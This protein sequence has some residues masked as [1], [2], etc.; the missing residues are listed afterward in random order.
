LIDLKIVKEQY[1]RMPDEELLRFATNESQKLTIES[2]HLLKS[3][4]ESR[5]L[6]LTILERVQTEKELAEA[7]QL[8]EFEKNTA[9]QFAETIWQFAFDEKEKGKS[10]QEIYN[11]LLRKN[12]SEN[13]AY[14]L[15]E[16]LEPRA[17]ELVDSFE[18]EII[19]GWIFTIAGALLLL[20]TLNLDEIQMTFLIWG[21]LMLLGGIIRLGASYS[22][23]RKYQTILTNI[24][25]EKE[26]ENNLYQ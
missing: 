4:F 21:T 26:V 1:E 7:M 24:E 11:A 12:I 22:K 18:N 16:S 13:Y 15:I 5:N 23:K 2:F 3:E 10:N 8:S 20:Y 25:T 9:S 19:V 14:M 17:K 6:D